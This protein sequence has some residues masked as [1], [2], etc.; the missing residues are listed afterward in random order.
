ERKSY[1]ICA[2]LDVMPAFSPDHVGGERSPL[3]TNT[4]FL[5][6]HPHIAEAFHI[7]NGSRR[8]KSSPNSSLSPVGPAWPFKGKPIRVVSIRIPRQ[9]CPKPEEEI[10]SRNERVVKTRT[11]RTS[12]INVRSVYLLG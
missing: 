9:P 3:R 11:I 4:V 6:S 12:I 5:I 10:R 2:Y 1:Q 8:A 7:D